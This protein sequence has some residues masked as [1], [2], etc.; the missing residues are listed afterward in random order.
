MLLN[1]K[2]W[3]AASPH[4]AQGSLTAVRQWAQARDGQFRAVHDGDGFV[5][6]GR[7]GQTAW[8][9]EWGP[10]QRSYVAGRELRLRAELGVAADLSLLVMNRA[11]QESM[12]S[13]VFEQYVEGVQTRIDEQTPP[14]MRWLV[15]FPKLARQEMGCL[16]ENFVGVASSKIWLAQWI[17]GSLC[18]ALAG[19]AL[20]AAHP[21]VLMVGRGRLVLRTRLDEASEARLEAWLKV[22][23]T[24]IREARR[25]ANHLSAVQGPSTQPSLW[26]STAAPV[27]EAK[28]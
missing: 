11:L 6:D 18:A 1:L 4:H 7:S 10:S 22:F 13:A 23:E 12:E 17:D 20:E 14:E 5:I 3:F 15:M 21:M 2:R 25:V 27:E 26:S 16:H 9:M 24:A 19:Q 8:R 28:A